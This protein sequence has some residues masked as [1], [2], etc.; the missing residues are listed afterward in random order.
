MRLAKKRSTSGLIALSPLETRNH[1]GIVFHPAFVA[2]S[3]SEAAAT[4]RWLIDMRC[5]TSSSRSAQ[6]VS[7]KSAWSMYNS[8]PP[9]APTASYGV[10]RAVDASMAGE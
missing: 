9:A 7:L 1:D 8:G 4:G 5:A 6:K 2:G 3:P 10:G